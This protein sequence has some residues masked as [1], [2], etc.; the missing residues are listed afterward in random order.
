MWDALNPDGSVADPLARKVIDWMQGNPVAPE[1]QLPF[2]INDVYAQAG[3]V[4]KCAMKVSRA[5]DGG[6]FLPYVSEKPPCGCYF[7]AKASGKAVPFGCVQCTDNTGC[8][9]KQIC[10]YGFCELAW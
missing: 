6:P 10:S 8:S 7:E 4:P 2:D 3:V 5:V 9:A 1:D